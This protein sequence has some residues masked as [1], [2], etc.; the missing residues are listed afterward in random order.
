MNQQQ[1]P[2]PPTPER[3]L[4]DSLRASEERFRV[5]FDLSMIGMVMADLDGTIQRVNDAFCLIVGRTP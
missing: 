1:T 3:Q 2:I 4:E 5:A